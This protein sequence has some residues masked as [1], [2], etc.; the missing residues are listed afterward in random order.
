MAKKSHIIQ[1]QD[2]LIVYIYSNGKK[3][4]SVR[5]KHPFLFAVV[6][7]NLMWKIT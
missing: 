5:E 3:E 1:G 6:V 7:V 2:T 4:I